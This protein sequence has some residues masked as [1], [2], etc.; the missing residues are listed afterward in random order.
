MSRWCLVVEDESPLGE[1]I[2]DNLAVE[3]YGTELVRDGQRALDRI[4]KG[5]IDLVILDIMLPSMD[6]F[7]VLQRMREAGDSTPVLILS[8][9]NSDQ[10]RIQGLEL[11]ADDYM[12]KPF[13]LRELLLRVA[14]LMR[15]AA[16]VPEG[17]DVVDCSGC[18][19]DFRTRQFH[20]R[21]GDIKH[22]NDSEVKL[23]R[24]LAN[25]SGE[26]LTRREILDHLYGPS[27]LPAARTLDNLILGLRHLFEDNGKKPRIL[28]TVRGVGFRF[29]PYAESNG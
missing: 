23:L 20:S 25:R 22:L 5:G 4:Q 12:T 21:S 13:N 24:L 14:A 1:L 15:R 3:G 8:A 17:A 10:D 18:R 6:G 28:H 27:S 16:T 19:V 9:R 7:A 11:L 29:T 26:V 2:C